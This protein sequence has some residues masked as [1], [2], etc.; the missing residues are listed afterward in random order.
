M[1]P[2]FVRDLEQ[3]IRNTVRKLRADGTT[4][5]SMANLKGVTPTPMDGPKGTNAQWVY[6]QI[7][8]EAA[9]HSAEG[10]VY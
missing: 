5:M 7:F 4:G 6:Q 1:S 2:T 9:K 3:S 8:T 10:F